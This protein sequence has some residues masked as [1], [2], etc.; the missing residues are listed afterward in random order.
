MRYFKNI[1][2]IC[3]FSLFLSG[4]YEW[5]VRFWN[6]ETQKLSPAEEKVS[7]E[8]FQELESIPEPKA[9]IGSKEMQ[10]WLINVYG[11]AK[12]ECMKRKGF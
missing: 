12:R 11:P 6:G 4:C 10:D 7:D 2:T 5:V 9:Y 1:I 8:C 3:F